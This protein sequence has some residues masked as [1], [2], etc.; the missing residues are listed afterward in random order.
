MR[1]MNQPRIIPESLTL[2]LVGTYLV[3]Y[4]YPLTLTCT[5]PSSL[6]QEYV[7]IYWYIEICNGPENVPGTVGNTTHAVPPP[8]GKSER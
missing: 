2:A 1:G 7:G 5:G 4:R 8:E 6:M 3:L